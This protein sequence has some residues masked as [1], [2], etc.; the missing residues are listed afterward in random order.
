MTAGKLALNVYHGMRCGAKPCDVRKLN[1]LHS[2]CRD[3]Q[4]EVGLYFY[5][6]FP[7]R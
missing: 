6:Y 4:S 5:G 1:S 7:C 3:P 2:S